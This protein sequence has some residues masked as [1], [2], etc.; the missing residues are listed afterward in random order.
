VAEI[1]A[2]NANKRNKQLTKAG[3]PIGVGTGAT[4]MSGQPVN[5]A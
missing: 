5:L 3:A 4:G 2:L 1:N